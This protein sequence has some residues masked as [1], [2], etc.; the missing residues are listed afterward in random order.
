MGCVVGAEEW[1]V[2]RRMEGVARL[3]GRKQGTE[4]FQR[5]EWSAVSAASERAS[6]LKTKR[7]SLDLAAEFQWSGRC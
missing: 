4:C 1:G 5:Q 7:F 3:V 6:T 2:Q